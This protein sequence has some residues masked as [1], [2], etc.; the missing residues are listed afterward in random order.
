MKRFSLRAPLIS[1]FLLAAMTL[2]LSGNQTQAANWY[3][4]KH[5]S[6]KAQAHSQAWPPRSGYYG[7]SHKEYGWGWFG[8]RYRGSMYSHRGYYGN[9]YQWGYRASY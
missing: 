2:A 5:Y 4:P 6:H 1:L 8:A 7:F 9:T 3:S